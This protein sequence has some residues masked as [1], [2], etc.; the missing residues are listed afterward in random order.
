MLSLPYYYMMIQ[1]PHLDLL[2]LPLFH[3]SH[4]ITPLGFGAC[5]QGQT[6]DKFLGLNPFGNTM[7]LM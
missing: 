3:A 7:G 2:F 1:Y 5:S 6:L 4:I